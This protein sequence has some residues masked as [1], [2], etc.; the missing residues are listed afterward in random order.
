[1]RQHRAPFKV[2]LVLA[3]C[4][5]LFC[6]FHHFI[7]KNKPMS[8]TELVLTSVVVV[9]GEAAPGVYKPLPSALSVLQEEE[10]R[11]TSH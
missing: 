2:S 7:F 11:Y 8:G 9:V 5:Y 3:F 10:T 4:N 1:M 6:E